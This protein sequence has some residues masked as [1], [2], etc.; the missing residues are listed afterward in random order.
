M[1][2][3]LGLIPINNDMYFLFA[4]ILSSD[5]LSHPALFNKGIGSY[6]HNIQQCCRLFKTVREHRWIK[7]NLASC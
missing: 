2:K 4:N 5:H 6:R 1:E 7:E 3:N